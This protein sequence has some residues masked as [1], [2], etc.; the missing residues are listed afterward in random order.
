MAEKTFPTFTISVCSKIYTTQMHL[1]ASVVCIL[2][3]YGIIQI[4]ISIKRGHFERKNSTVT[5]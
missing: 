4:I 1:S 3:C 2:E 5:M